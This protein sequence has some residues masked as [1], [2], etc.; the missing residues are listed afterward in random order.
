MMA[1]AARA[2]A[3]WC[4][5]LLAGAGAAG[6]LLWSAT[7]A[8]QSINVTPSSIPVPVQGV[9][10]S[11]TFVGSNGVAPYQFLVSTGVL[12]VGL[13]LSASGALTGTPTT[14]A[15]Y[16]F[17]ITVSDFLGRELDLTG[18][19]AVTSTLVITP[20]P[21]LLVNIPYSGQIQVTGGTGPYTFAINSGTLPPGMSLS[22]SGMLVGTPTA[23]G[24]YVLVIQVTDAN[25]LS[26]VITLN[27]NV[28]ALATGIPVN[29]PWMLALAALGLGWL[30]RRQLR[31]RQ[32][33]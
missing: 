7:A 29:E 32:Q 17:T 3:T 19:G 15:A 28:T 30:G 12:P 21:A 9:P 16:S 5:Q 27:I 11:V 6:L 23:P 25:G 14:A 13:S 8:A 1:R 20:P 18:T 10:Y 22:A 24:S 26:S 33:Y 4:R 2:A 31:Q